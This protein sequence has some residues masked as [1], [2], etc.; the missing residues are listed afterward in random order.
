MSLD[1]MKQASEAE[2]AAKLALQEATARSRQM[3]ADAEKEGRM[4]QEQQLLEAEEQ[5]R[6]M[7]AEAEKTGEANTENTMHHAEN[8]CAVLRAHAESRLSAASDRIVERIVM[9]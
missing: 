5:V 1:A 4:F 3:I 7:M 9:G 6:Q 2:N 8:Q